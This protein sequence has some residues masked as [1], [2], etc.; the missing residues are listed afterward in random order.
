LGKFNFDLC[1]I[2]IE[3]YTADPLFPRMALLIRR[4]IIVHRVIGSSL[5]HGRSCIGAW[6]Q[7]RRRLPA[8]LVPHGMHCKTVFAIFGTGC[9]CVLIVSGKRAEEGKATEDGLLLHQA[10]CFLL[11]VVPSPCQLSARNADVI[12]INTNTD[13]FM[14][15]N[16]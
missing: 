14:Y 9:P 1:G 11:S 16:N 15:I 6:N 2:N 3:L 13:V 8:C 7:N 4:K 12:P 5:F 10:L